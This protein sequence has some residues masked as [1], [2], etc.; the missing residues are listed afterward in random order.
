MTASDPEVAAR[1]TLALLQNRLHRL[2]FL[3]TG[4]TNEEGIPELSPG[5]TQAR[6]NVWSRLDSLS[7]QLASLKTLSGPAGVVVKDI[8]RLCRLANMTTHGSRLTMF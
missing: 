6:D 3:L 5:T 1:A 8:D 7:S 4:I 2:E